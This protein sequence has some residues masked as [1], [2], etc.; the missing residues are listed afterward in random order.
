MLILMPGEDEPLL[1]GLT[2]IQTGTVIK[3]GREFN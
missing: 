3:S 2:E 1:N